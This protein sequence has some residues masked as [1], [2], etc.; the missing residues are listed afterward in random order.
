MS[1][2]VLVLNSGGIKGLVA[3]ATLGPGARPVMMFVHD[4]RPSGAQ[5][6][7]AFLQ[8][9]VHFDA[10]RR[11]EL[12]LGHLVLGEGVAVRSA[13]LA[14][15]QLLAAAA[16]QAVQLG[17]ARLVLPVCV[18]DSFDDLAQITEA[19]VLL[20]HAAQVESGHAL[21]VETPLLDMTLEQVIEVGQKLGVPWR[22]ARVC[23]QRHPRPCG[24]CSACRTYAQA[25]S[26][27]GVE[28]AVAGSDA[29]AETR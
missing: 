15:F 2:D 21:K 9:A 13:P 26:R 25:F 20:E 1:G 24:E 8:Q 18:G 11:V 16:G 14:R 28:Y 12:S 29:R 23:V 5:H 17:A 3:A 27:V 7:Q 4:G 19:L 10:A 22:L 6:Y